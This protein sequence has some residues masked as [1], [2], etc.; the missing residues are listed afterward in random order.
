MPEVFEN[1]GTALNGTFPKEKNVRRD[2]SFDV[3]SS[4]TA[5][6]PSSGRAGEVWAKSNAESGEF[7]EEKMVKN[8]KT[9]TSSPAK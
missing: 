5:T 9:I 7:N 1:G 4:L 8:P 6:T 2:G 3:L